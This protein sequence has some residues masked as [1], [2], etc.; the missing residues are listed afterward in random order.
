VLE[1][2]DITRPQQPAHLLLPR[3]DTSVP[4]HKDDRS[5]YEH[6]A[7]L[8][9]ERSDVASHNGDPDVRKTH[10]DFR[11]EGAAISIAGLGNADPG[12]GTAPSPGLG[13]LA[14]IRDFTSDLALDPTTSAPFIADPPGNAAWAAKALYSHLHITQGRFD[15]VDSIPAGQW[16]FSDSLSKTGTPGTKPALAVRIHWRVQRVASLVITLTPFDGST[17][18]TIQL[19][20]RPG[21]FMLQL[22]NNCLP[23]SLWD[24][25]G[26]LCPSTTSQIGEPELRDIDFKWLFDLMESTDGKSIR[27]RLADSSQAPPFKELPVPGLNHNPYGGGAATS[28]TRK[29]RTATTETCVPGGTPHP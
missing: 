13:S 23:P 2:G 1:H 3:A 10:F 5:T 28:A 17:P 29:L 11:L 7:W 9:V 14:N 8:C 19:T 6:G 15:T 12:P 25:T 20:N 26:H 21:D 24:S 22:G 27:N 4:T 18:T 16:H